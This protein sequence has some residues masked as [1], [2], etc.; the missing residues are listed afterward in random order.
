[1][2]LCKTCTKCFP[3]AS[4]PSF[5]WNFGRP[6]IRQAGEEGINLRNDV[7]ACSTHSKSLPFSY[8]CGWDFDSI[9]LEV[10]QTASCNLDVKSSGQ[11]KSWH[12]KLSMWANIDI[13]APFTKQANKSN[14]FLVI[15][16][17]GRFHSLVKIWCSVLSQNFSCSKAKI[18][19][20]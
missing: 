10:V 4:M 18:S 6:D 15:G 7:I 16:L 9:P 14:I 11:V 12:E 17:Y 3:H 19:V 8:S 2:S 13:W 20:L 1:M 5:R